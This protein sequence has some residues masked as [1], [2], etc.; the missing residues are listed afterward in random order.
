MKNSLCAKEYEQEKKDRDLPA[1]K[2][3]GNIHPELKLLDRISLS[4]NNISSFI[5]PDDEDT[6][7]AYEAPSPLTS[8][9][10]S[11][12][13]YSSLNEEEERRLG[14]QIKESEDDVKT[15]VIQWRYLFNKEYLKLFA[16]DSGKEIALKL[17][18]LKDSFQLFENLEAFEKE[19]IKIK[20]ALEKQIS[21]M[22]ELLN[23]QEEINKIEAEISKC[24]A[25]IN[26]TK[27]IIIRVFNRLKKIGI[28]FSQIWI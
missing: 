4:E 5:K 28:A 22:K 26:L 21:S 23:L 10:K 14:R 17:Q 2:I 8:Y 20:S 1:E 12:R 27:P 6:D 7:S 16:A 15:L 25:G 24:I 18:S 3:I 19:R 11:I 9:F 13:N